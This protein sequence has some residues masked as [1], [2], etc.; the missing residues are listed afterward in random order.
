MGEGWEYVIAGADKADG[1][2]PEGE[3][4]LHAER[5]GKDTLELPDTREL[6]S[7]SHGKMNVAFDL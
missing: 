3:D 5:M 7:F 2:A 1:D 6:Y 4:T